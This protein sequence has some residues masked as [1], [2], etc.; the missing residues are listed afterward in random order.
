[1]TSETHASE[2]NLEFIAR[3]RPRTWVMI[4][5]PLAAALL[6]YVGWESLGTD[7]SMR[8][9]GAFL[10]D[11]PPWLRG[12]FFFGVAAVC[13]GGWLQQLRRKLS[14]QVE[15][16]ADPQGITSHLFWGKGRLCWPDIVALERK[17]NWLFVRGTGP[18]AKP[19]KLVIDTMSIDAP[20][21]SLYAIIAHHRP[22]LLA[23]A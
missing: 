16:E 2:P 20:I 3:S 19:K 14:P 18:N 12:A 1:M 5:L 11:L 7:F 23:R 22:D 4:V 9:R 21:D 15:V 10:N 17:G 6:I 13:L 8:G